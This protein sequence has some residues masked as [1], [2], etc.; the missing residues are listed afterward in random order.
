MKLWILYTVTTVTVPDFGSI[1][2]SRSSTWITDFVVVSINR[3]FRSEGEEGEGEAEAEVSAKG[4]VDGA[5]G[6]GGGGGVGLFS[7]G[8]G[9]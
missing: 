7:V 2:R 6:G 1:N 3:N 8:E 4:R 5:V 9:E